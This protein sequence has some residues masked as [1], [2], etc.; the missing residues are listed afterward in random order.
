[1]LFRSIVLA[2]KRLIRCNRARIDKDYQPVADT[3][4]EIVIRGYGTPEIEARQIAQA[5]AA[6]IEQGNT[7]ASI[8]VLYRTGTIA[9]WLGVRLGPS[10]RF[11]SPLIERS[12][13][14]SRTTLSDWLHLMAHGVSPRSD[15]A[16][17]RPV[18]PESFRERTCVS[19]APP[20]CDDARGS[21]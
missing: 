18:L 17:G 7:P 6:L 4:G 2:A 13:R 21:D 15:V 10:L 12:V 5:I 19:R 11:L 20:P 1:M 14:I 9:R 8:A 16:Q 3:A